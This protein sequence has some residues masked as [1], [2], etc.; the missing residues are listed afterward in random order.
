[1]TTTAGRPREFDTTAA[2]DAALTVFWKQGFEGTST[3]DLTAA[4]GISKPSMY[5]VFGNKKELFCK[6]LERYCERNVSLP[7]ILTLP[8]AYEVAERF[9]SK[10]MLPMQDSP[11]PQEFVGCMVTQGALTCSPV[12]RDMVEALSNK[13]HQ[14]QTMLEERFARAQAEGDL[15]PTANAAELAAYISTVFHGLAVQASAGL[16]CA[17]SAAIVAMALKNFSD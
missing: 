11:D 2:L 7:E 4:M 10:S 5:A 9:L 15:P 17:E 12:N 6:A 13:R 8:T 16:S 14:W 3:A 1:M